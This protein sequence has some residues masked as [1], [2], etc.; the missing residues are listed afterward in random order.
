MS[1]L[2]DSNAYQPSLNRVIKHLRRE[3]N[4]LYNCLRSIVADTAFVREISALYPG[5]P[6]AAN[7]RCGLWYTPSPDLTCYFKSTDGHFGNW[8]FSLTRLNTHIALRAA[9]DGGCLIVDATRR[10]KVFPVRHMRKARM[11]CWSQSEL[12]PYSRHQTRME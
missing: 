7:L 9:E 1:A 6:V 3:E 10:G 5:T 8:S 4:S 12:V 11:H 2:Q